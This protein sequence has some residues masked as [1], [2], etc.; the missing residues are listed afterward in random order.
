MKVMS[1][2]PHQ[3]L[4]RWNRSKIMLVGQGR[5]GKTALANN[6]AGRWMGETASTIGAEQMDMRL[7]YGG[8]K[9]GRLE[10]YERPKQESTTEFLF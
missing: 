9:G 6:L 8:V 10:E 4:V 5:A 1:L 3:K 2:L 7:L